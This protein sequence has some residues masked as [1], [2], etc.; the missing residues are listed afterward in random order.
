[1]YLL[2]SFIIDNRKK[3]DVLINNAGV[4]KIDSIN[5]ISLK[6]WK[7]MNNINLY[8]PFLLT[9][10]FSKIMI[11]KKY[12]RIINISSIWGV[13][14]KEKLWIRNLNV[15]FHTGNTGSLLVFRTFNIV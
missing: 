14:S 2:K 3:V 8:G 10:E 11:K 9:K 7:I 15:F 1:M 6:D 13:V 5:N 12:G 4:N